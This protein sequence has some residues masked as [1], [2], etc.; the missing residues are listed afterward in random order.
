MKSVQLEELR[1]H[2]DDYVEEAQG[3]EA[4]EICDGQRVLA[5]LVRP[6]TDQEHYDR[7]V[8]EGAIEPPSAQLPAD[9]FTRTPI[10]LGGG[11]LEQFL[12]D[13]RTGR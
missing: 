1:E 3:G 13:R 10:D 6:L 12:E 7:L 9:F 8:R 4:V 2:L 11:V 5:T